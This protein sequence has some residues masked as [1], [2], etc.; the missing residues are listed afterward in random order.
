[1][2]F[3]IEVEGNED[4]ENEIGNS[5]GMEMMFILSIFFDNWVSIM[6]FLVYWVV[7]VNFRIF[8]LCILLDV[9]KV[10]LI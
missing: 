4:D 3:Q 2:M 1:M 9:S 6:I 7:D 8:Q 5:N 10:F